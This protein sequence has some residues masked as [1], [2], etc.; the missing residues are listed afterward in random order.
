DQMGEALGEDE[1][2]VEADTDCS[3]SK[4]DVLSRIERD[5]ELCVRDGQESPQTRIG[6]GLES[7]QTS[8]GDGQESP[9]TTEEMDQ[10]EEALGEDKVPVEADTE[11]PILVMNVM[12]LSAQKEELRREDEPETEM[13]DDPAESSTKEGFLLGNE[14]AC[15]GAS[16]PGN[17]KVKEE[18]PE[19]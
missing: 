13:E 17:V 19:A 2:P 7:P 14:M 15:E 12:S 16:P 10:K 18:E 6:D 8:V 1:V 4:P 9:Q 5:E 3:V 11:L